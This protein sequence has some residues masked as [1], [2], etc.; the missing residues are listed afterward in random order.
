MERGLI[1]M[2][3]SY[4]AAWHS[5]YRVNERSARELI[6]DA[7]FSFELVFSGQKACERASVHV[8]SK[9]LMFSNRESESNS[10]ANPW[11]KHST[12]DNFPDGRDFFVQTGI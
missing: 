7:G 6:Q 8:F 12:F 10:R 2:N 4:S 5:L 11:T 9:V 3:N 1:V